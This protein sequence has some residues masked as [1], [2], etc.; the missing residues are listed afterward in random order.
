MA[1]EGK[2]WVNNYHMSHSFSSTMASKATDL[3]REV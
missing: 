1:G 3:E 2:D